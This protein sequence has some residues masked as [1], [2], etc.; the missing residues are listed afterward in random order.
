MSHVQAA[1][2]ERVKRDK[3]GKTVM[4][5]SDT[6]TEVRHRRVV[7]SGLDEI[8][9]PTRVTDPST[10]NEAAETVQVFPQAEHVLRVLADANRPM[11]DDEIGTA[12]HLHGWS[13]SAQGLRTRRHDMT[14][15]GYVR[16]TDRDGRTGSGRACRRFEITE[17]GR[18]VILTFEE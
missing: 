14:V 8:S 18:E 6:T 7:C 3:Q 15:L 13:G 2:D 10:S 9:A 17:R 12:V 1:T 11:T 4:K 16:E 5:V